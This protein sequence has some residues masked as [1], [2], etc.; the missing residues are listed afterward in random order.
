MKA[1]PGAVI[2]S[3][4]SMIGAAIGSRGTVSHDVHDEL[5]IG[6]F[7][8]LQDA[9]KAMSAAQ[10]FVDLYSACGA[11]TCTLDSRTSYHR[12]R[13]LIYN[14]S[15]NSVAAITGLDVS[16]MRFSE[17]VIDSLV[18]PIMLEI[19]AI[20][21]ADGIQLEDAL[22]DRM[23]VVDP[24]AAFFLPSMGQD[25]VSG[26]YIEFE[27]IVGEP[28]RTAQRLGVAVPTLEVVYALLKAKQW[29]ILE[30][31]GQVSVPQDGVPGMKYA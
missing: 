8:G 15:F 26:N 27:N 30:R 28:L 17:H 4:I 31:K 16:R 13:K 5:V 24:Y 20:A 2:I 25:A 6:P 12:W 11:V 3:G 10:R 18:R 14:A 7:A 29:Q 1:F 9:E 23:I 19:V 21:A 22:V